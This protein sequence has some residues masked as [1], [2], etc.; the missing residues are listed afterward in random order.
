MFPKTVELNITRS[1]CRRSWWSSV[2]RPRPKR[3]RP[4]RRKRRGAGWSCRPEPSCRGRGEKGRRR[5]GT[6]VDLGGRP[7]GPPE[8][9]G[10]ED[11]WSGFLEAFWRDL[12]GKSHGFF[13]LGR[14]SG[15]NKYLK[16]I[17][18]DED[19]C[20]FGTQKSDGKHDW[21]APGPSR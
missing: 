16:P 4:K 3:P 21:G 20:S 7:W 17:Q 14:V 9:S 5:W 13:Q 10:D 2:T 12:N 1:V 19:F 18:Y 11:G 6:L 15:E 8:I